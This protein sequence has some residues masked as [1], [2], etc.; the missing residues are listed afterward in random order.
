[1]DEFEER[2]NSLVDRLD[3]LVASPNVKVGREK[4]ENVIRCD[5][6]SQRLKAQ[7]K[8]K[9]NEERNRNREIEGRK[10]VVNQS[11]KIHREKK[12]KEPLVVDRRKP[13]MKKI[14][15]KKQRNEGKRKV[16]VKQL[17]NTFKAGYQNESN[18]KSLKDWRLELNGRGTSLLQYV[19]DKLPAYFEPTAHHHV[20]T[21]NINTREAFDFYD[22]LP[23]KNKEEQSQGERLLQNC[24]DFPTSYLY[25]SNDNIRTKQKDEIE[26]VCSICQ[27]PMKMSTLLQCKFFPSYTFP[28]IPLT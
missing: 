20:S 28:L 5:H 6:V 25:E 7:R 11:V 27:E 4:R 15:L 9:N 13:F 2:L 10:E 14:S 22:Q 18:V 8:V 12:I 21:E 24:I 16:T 17:S 26:T 1:M 3:V 23:S 19:N